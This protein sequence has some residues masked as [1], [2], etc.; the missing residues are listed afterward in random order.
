MSTCYIGKSIASG[1]VCAPPSKSYAHRL[2]LAAFLSRKQVTISNIELSNDIS[3]TIDCIQ[4]LGGQ[5]SVAGHSVTVS[6]TSGDAPAV[7]DCRESGS[8][9]RFMIPVALAMRSNATFTGTEKLFSRGLGEY[10]KIFSSQG[11]RYAK[12]A[13]SLSVNG[14]LCSGSFNIDG[15]ISSQYITG[16]L[17]ALPLLDGDS[18]ITITP[19]IQSRPYID[20]TLDVLQRAGVKA[21]MEGC[22]IDIPGG[23]SYNLGDCSVEGDWSNAAF[24]DIYNYLGGKV[25]IEGLNT[26]SLQGDKIYREYFE[27]LSQGRCTIDLANCIDLGPVLFTMAA[28]KHGARFENTARLRIKESDRVSD[29]LQELAKVGAKSVC[30]D[31]FVEIEPFVAD[32]LKKEIIF[33]SHNDHRL[34]MS[35]SALASTI[36][37]RIDG[38]EAVAKS[39]PDF[40]N[41]LKHLNI[42]VRN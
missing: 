11:I 3:A 32:N 6:A 7:L 33:S 41:V 28:I 15:S 37:A 29:I 4:T 14:R 17:F 34:A 27:K 12:S 22:R 18:C 10:E 35:L 42:D 39:F 30:G 20:I 38:C 9:L 2:L 19:P 8:T 13:S 1:T 36:G 24:L 25:Q 16:L 23:Q 26:Q 5:V 31:N 21:Y 40:Y